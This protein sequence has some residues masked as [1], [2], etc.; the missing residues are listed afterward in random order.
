MSRTAFVLAGGGSLGAVQVGMLK[1]LATHGVHADLV[2]GASVGAING[3]HYAADPSAEGMARLERIWCGL[4][5]RDVFARAP[6]AALLALVRGRAHVV[7][8]ASF[9]G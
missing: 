3:A 4:R 1:A 6:L 5:R 7:D 2:V 9:A 8:P